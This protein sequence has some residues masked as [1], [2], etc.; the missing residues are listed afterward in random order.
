VGEKRRIN[1]WRRCCP[2]LRNGSIDTCFSPRLKS[3]V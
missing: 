3:L 1:R 2:K